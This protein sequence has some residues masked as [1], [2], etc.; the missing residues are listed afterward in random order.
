MI[1]IKLPLLFK[2]TPLSTHSKYPKCLPLRDRVGEFQSLHGA[3]L[4]F[5]RNLPEIAS[6]VKTVAGRQLS[7]TN[8]V[9]RRRRGGTEASALRGINA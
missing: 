3:H 1:V 9:P 5:G 2:E 7:Q 8:Q 6:D 4:S